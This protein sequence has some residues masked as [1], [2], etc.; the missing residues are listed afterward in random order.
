MLTTSSAGSLLGKIMGNSPT[1][2]RRTP[3]ASQDPA[4]VVLLLQEL[5]WGRE[6]LSGIWKGQGHQQESL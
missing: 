4:T 3:A 1:R 6:R 5:N 2:R